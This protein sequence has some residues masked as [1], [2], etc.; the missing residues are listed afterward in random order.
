MTHNVNVLDYLP[1]E[2]P[3]NIF[4]SIF[5]RSNY[6]L[7]FPEDVKRIIIY[8]LLQIMHCNDRVTFIE[9]LSPIEY[10]T[11]LQMMP[12]HNRF[13]F[14]Q[15]IDGNVNIDNFLLAI[16]MNLLNFSRGTT[17]FMFKILDTTK[18]VKFVFK[19]MPYRINESSIEDNEKEI[20]DINDPSH[21]QNVDHRVAL[22]LNN[23][24]NISAQHIVTYYATFNSNIEN[25]INQ[26]S[27]DIN[28]N[29]YDDQYYNIV[30]VN[31]YEWCDGGNLLN[32]IRE[33][34]QSM[35]LEQ[36]TIIFFQL[37]FTLAT[38][39]LKYP[40]FRHNCLKAN[41]IL[42][43]K[44]NQDLQC[45]NQY[46]LDNKCFIIPD[47]G[48]KIKISDFDFACIDGIINNDKVD[49]LWCEIINIT[50]KENK[51]YDIH[52]F[53]NT[54]TQPNFFPQFYQK[55]AVPQEIID[56]VHRILPE[57]YRGRNTNYLGNG[58]RIL[59]NTEYT[60][61]YKVIMEDPLFEKY[62]I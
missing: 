22:L 36:W 34:Y 32:Y 35:T 48:L 26:P 54:L 31:V 39:Q 44:T 16:H 9:T 4:F 61:P 14:F 55:Y 25:F 33:N 27:D 23:L 30:T 62:R 2:L 15:T 60:T 17:S 42:L 21:E 3:K 6:I 5:L 8:I 7:P 38:I 40:T 24:P 46:S 50:R 56:F 58:G 10:N 12:V 20:C 29:S 52:Y 43:K 13:I 51:Y 45:V 47:I 57:R 28:I 1:H 37:L 18:N 19:V 49:S 59:V 41:D 53:F 11:F